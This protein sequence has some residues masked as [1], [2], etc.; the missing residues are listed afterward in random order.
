MDDARSEKLYRSLQ[1]VQ[2]RNLTLWLA[3]LQT[4]LCI[5]GVPRF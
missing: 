1:T 5:E 4:M 3:S 2:V